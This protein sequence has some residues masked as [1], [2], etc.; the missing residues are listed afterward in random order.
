MFR[1]QFNFNNNDIYSNPGNDNNKSF[2]LK[3]NDNGYHYLDVQGVSS[4]TMEING[5]ADQCDFINMS[6][7]FDELHPALQS[8]F[9]IDDV[10]SSG[11]VDYTRL[12]SSRGEVFKL[13]SNAQN[14]FNGLDQEIR[15]HFNNSFELFYSQIGSNSF[16]DF[17]NKL[18]D[19]SESEVTE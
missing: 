10:F 7:M 13:I 2:I 18:Y 17:F 8:S 14:L 19:N 9:N 5:Y 6:K 16:R 4:W 1:T 12:P 11:V 15:E 3:V